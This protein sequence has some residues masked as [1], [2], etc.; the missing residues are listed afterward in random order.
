MMCGGLGDSKQADDD[1]HQIVQNVN[2]IQ[3]NEKM[4]N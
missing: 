4:I 3:K 1:I 2:K